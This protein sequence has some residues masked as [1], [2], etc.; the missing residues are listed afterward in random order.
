MGTVYVVHHV[1]TEGPLREDLS[2]LF[3]R[4]DQ[5]FGI[6]LPANAENLRLLQNGQFGNS[7][8]E[9]SE[10]QRVVSSHSLNFKTSWHEIDSMLRVILSES[11]RSSKPDSDGRGWIYNWHIMDHVG[12]E[13]NPRHRDMGYLNIFNH[14]EQALGDR[15]S[16]FDSMEWH[17]H[18]VGFFRHAHIPAT[19]YDTSLHL[20]H[21]SLS[22]RVIEKSFFPVVNRPGFHSVR[23]DSA[24]F[25]EQWIPFDASNQCVSHAKAHR[26]QK[27]LGSGRFGDWRGAPADWS[28]YQPDYM[29]W[30]RPGSCKRYVSRVLNLNSRHNSIDEEEIQIAFSTAR[31]NGD[32]YLGVTNHDWREMSKEI[33]DFRNLLQLVRTRHPDVRVVYSDAVNAFRRVV[34]FD[35]HT[36]AVDALDFACSVVDSRLVVEIKNGALFGPQPYLALKT[37]WGDYY[38]DNFDFQEPRSSF[39]YTFDSYTIPLQKVSVIGVAGN[40]RYGN[41]LVVRLRRIGEDFEVQKVRRYAIESIAQPVR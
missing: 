24:F 4:L 2:E 8:S 19:K 9:R 23:P 32:S 6:R 39:S 3:A 15:A 40:D 22:R 41:S 28:L 5:I 12:F 21:Q 29:D 18:P 11:F 1:D 27:D 14:Y 34:G 10:I 31:R 13:T 25:L 38:H 35:D 37:V 30:R 33:D 26:Y 17:C 7:D 36:V 16:R 20:F